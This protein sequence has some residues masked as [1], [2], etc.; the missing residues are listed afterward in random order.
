[1]AAE[2]RESY[3]LDLQRRSAFLYAQARIATDRAQVTADWWTTDGPADAIGAQQWARREWLKS[4]NV[5][6]LFD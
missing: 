4:A 6:G 5:R 3:L 2:T 1:M